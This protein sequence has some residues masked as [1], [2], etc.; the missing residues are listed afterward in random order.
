MHDQVAVL[1]DHERNASLKRRGQ[2]ARKAGNARGCGGQVFSDSSIGFWLPIEARKQW[3]T[4]CP[5]LKQRGQGARKAGNARGASLASTHGAGLSKW[6]TAGS[7]AFANS[8]CAM[9][10]FTPTFIVLNHMAAVII[11]FRKVPLTINSI[12]GQ[13]LNEG[14]SIVL[15]D[16]GPF[17]G[18]V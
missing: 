17:P 3:V 14:R 2:G 7:A 13:A 1:A 12:Y 11:G 10:S 16:D 5:V 8:G 18:V 6:P 4:S 9:K 15:L